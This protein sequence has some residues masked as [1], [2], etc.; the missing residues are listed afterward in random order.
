MC[1]C[2]QEG[3]KCKLKKLGKIKA[4]EGEEKGRFV[5]LHHSVLVGVK[6][7]YLPALQADCSSLFIREYMSWFMR[8]TAEILF[9]PLS[10]W[11]WEAVHL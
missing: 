3:R 4:V 8:N 10:H 7:E 2:G 5:L 6:K 9:G 11:K 1:K